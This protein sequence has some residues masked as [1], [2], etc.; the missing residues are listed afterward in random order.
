MTTTGVT[1]CR[2]CGAAV[3][4]GYDDYAKFAVKVDRRPVSREVELLCVVAARKVY[5]VDRER[6]LRLRTPQASVHR[7]SDY[8]LH[9]EHVCGAVLPALPAPMT[10]TFDTSAEPPF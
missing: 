3:L 6:R 4:S 9:P 2:K 1:T 7:A 10:A 5:E 8:D